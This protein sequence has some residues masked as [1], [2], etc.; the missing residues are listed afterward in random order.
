[1]KKK[2]VI[3]YEIVEEITGNDPHPGHLEFL[4]EEAESRISENI[5]N[6]F[7]AGELYSNLR[8]FC[9]DEEENTSTY[10]ASWECLEEDV[11]AEDELEAFNHDDDDA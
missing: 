10:R 6:G 7:R 11:D 3:T 2:L 5:Q 9:P 1:M 4:V 8:P